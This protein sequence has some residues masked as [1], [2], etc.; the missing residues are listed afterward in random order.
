MFLL[1]AQLGNGLY[2]PYSLLQLYGTQERQLRKFVKQIFKICFSKTF[3][4][5]VTVVSTFLLYTCA[6]DTC[7]FLCSFVQ[8]HIQV[9]M[10]FSD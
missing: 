1:L 7:V 2:L 9:K 4:L 8:R 3:E 10:V 5:T 6:R